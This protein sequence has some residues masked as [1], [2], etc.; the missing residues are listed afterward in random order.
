MNGL[1]VTDVLSIP[2]VNTNETCVY[3][4]ISMTSSTDYIT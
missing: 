1:F 2:I 3:T 4:I